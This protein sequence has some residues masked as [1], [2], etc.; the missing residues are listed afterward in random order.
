MFY[1]EVKFV[2]SKIKYI[3]FL[4]KKNYLLERNTTKIFAFRKYNWKNI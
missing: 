4:Q 1:Y 2:T 3:K